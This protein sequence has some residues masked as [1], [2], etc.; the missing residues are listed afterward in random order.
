MQLAYGAQRRGVDLK[1]VH[2]V[3]LLDRAYGHT[4]RPGGVA[5]G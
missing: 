4:A 3:D 5:T 2:V 1:L